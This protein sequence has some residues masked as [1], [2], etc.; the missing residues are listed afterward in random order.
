VLPTSR[1]HAQSGS[2]EVTV[3]KI[4][5]VRP[6]QAETINTIFDLHLSL[7]IM[8]YPWQFLS[9]SCKPGTQYNY[10]KRHKITSPGQKSLLHH[11]Q[12]PSRLINFYFKFSHP[13]SPPAPQTPIFQS[14]CSY[15]KDEMLLSSSLVGLFGV[16]AVVAAHLGKSVPKHKQLEASSGTTY[17]N[18]S[19]LVS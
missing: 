16:L 10:W 11:F 2:Y 13:L 7:T 14:R 3:H 1:H 12:T 6:E 17:V 18:N 9:S 4:F 15:S 5:A 8:S 19:F